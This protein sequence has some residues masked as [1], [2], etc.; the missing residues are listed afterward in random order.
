MC[1]CSEHEDGGMSLCPV[2]A[3][4]Y[5]MNVADFDN[6][7][8]YLGEWLESEEEWEL[9]THKSECNCLCHETKRLLERQ[10]GRVLDT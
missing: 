5:K 4:I 6:A 1:E 3:D 2:C 10:R 7:I 9:R 8:R